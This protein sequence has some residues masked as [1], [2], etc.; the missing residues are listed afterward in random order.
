MTDKL[1]EGSLEYLEDKVRT[2]HHNISVTTAILA[3]AVKALG[4]RL[5][6]TVTEVTD[7][8]LNNASDTCNLELEENSDGSIAYIYKEQE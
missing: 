6:L 7:F 1:T 3:L 2:L 5:E 4:G 8:V